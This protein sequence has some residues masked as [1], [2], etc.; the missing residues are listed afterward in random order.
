MSKQDLKEQMKRNRSED[1]DDD[2]ENEEEDGEDNKTEAE[3][4]GLSEEELASLYDKLGA[5]VL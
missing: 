5:L 4:N 1:D 2:D 3:E